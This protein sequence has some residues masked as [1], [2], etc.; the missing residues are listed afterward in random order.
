MSKVQN[1]QPYIKSRDGKLI[2]SEGMILERWKDH[3]EE[4]FKTG[5]EQQP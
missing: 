4:N 3:S 1:L 5:I 2:G